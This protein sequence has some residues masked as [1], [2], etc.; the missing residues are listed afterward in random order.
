MIIP[1]PSKSVKKMF[2]INSI[3]FS[4]KDNQQFKKIY[5][6]KNIPI[7]D[8]AFKTLY[9]AAKT[10]CD[11]CVKQ[12][13]NQSIDSNST[14][15]DVY[16]SQDFYSKVQQLFD[17]VLNKLGEP[18]LRYSQLTKR[19]INYEEIIQQA[20]FG[21]DETVNEF[22]KKYKVISEEELI[23]KL[24]QQEIQDIVSKANDACGRLTDDGILE[25]KYIFE[26]NGDKITLKKAQPNGTVISTENIEVTD[27]AQELREI[28]ERIREKIQDISSSINTRKQL[29]VTIIKQ[30]N[31]NDIN[32]FTKMMMQVQESTQNIP[33]EQLNQDI[34]IPEEEKNNVNALTKR[35]NDYYRTI[36]DLQKQVEQYETNI[37]EMKKR[38]YNVKVREKDQEALIQELTYTK[39]KL[40]EEKENHNNEINGILTEFGNTKAGLE[41]I[42]QKQDNFITTSQIAQKVG[43]ATSV[44]GTAGVA[45]VLAGNKFFPEKFTPVV[46]LIILSVVIVLILA[47]MF[48]LSQTVKKTKQINNE[49]PV[50]SKEREKETIT[51]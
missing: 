1:Q 20:S 43:M 7:D 47:T 19:I 9:E 46:N 6:D 40:K 14:Q 45:T 28:V 42:I 12:Q 36:A 5:K 2:P 26:K 17:N 23:G 48:A 15:N 49:Q 39:K 16:Y 8:M 27:V 3:H 25:N 51:K 38:E 30:A 50:V 11:I 33:T 24:S 34:K 4:L 31:I 21:I 13:H 37:N 29:L 32:K 41:E 10:A 44:F 22:K 18:M 35:V